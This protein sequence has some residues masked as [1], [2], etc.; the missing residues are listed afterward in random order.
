MKRC[1]RCLVLK[2]IRYECD[3]LKTRNNNQIHEYNYSCYECLGKY[4]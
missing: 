1:I 2:P 3:F 4:I